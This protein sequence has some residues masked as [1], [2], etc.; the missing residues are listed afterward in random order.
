MSSGTIN[1]KLQVIRDMLEGNGVNNRVLTAYQRLFD[2]E[3]GRIVLEDL[4]KR[5]FVYDTIAKRGCSSEDVL[6]NEG[7]RS[8]VLFILGL[9]NVNLAL[10]E[11]VLRRE[12]EE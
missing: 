7:K 3:D 1:K 6:L 12:I 4:A 10:Y 5:F 9:M 8:V 2:T 11:Q